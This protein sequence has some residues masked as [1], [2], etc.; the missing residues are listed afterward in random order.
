[1]TLLSETQCFSKGRADVQLFLVALKGIGKQFY[2]DCPFRVVCFLNVTWAWQHRLQ[3]PE[4][5][6]P[7]ELWHPSVQKFGLRDD[8]NNLLG[9][10]YLDPFQRAG[11]KVGMSKR[12]RTSNFKCHWSWLLVAEIGVLK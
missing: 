10:L 7:G 9:V 2:K 4:E 6:A 11:K 3:T 5:P 12:K 8:N 1:M